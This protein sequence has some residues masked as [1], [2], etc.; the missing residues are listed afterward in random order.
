MSDFLTLKHY[1]EPL[2]P[3]KKGYGYYGAIAMSKEDGRIQCHFCGELFDNLALHIYKIHDIT[4]TEY[5]LKFSLSRS[6]ALVSERVRMD[7]KEK[8]LEWMRRL[9]PEQKE[10]HMRRARAG[11]REWRKFKER[12]EDKNKKGTCPDQLLDTI[13]KC[14]EKLG[15]TPSKNEFIAHYDSQRFVH[16]IYKTFGSWTKAIKMAR[17]TASEKKAGKKKE[18]SN[19]ELL[20]Y[21]SIYHQENGNIPTESDARRG[22]IPDVGVYKRHFGSLPKARKLAGIQD[23]PSRWKTL[24]RYENPESLEVKE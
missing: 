14:A 13:K 4:A 23:V 17:L 6:S 19:E 1:K 16:L 21:L 2:R 18:Y 22:L 9:T 24:S 8:T 10:A 3:V 11:R 20:D 15:H 5:K 7:A 12:L